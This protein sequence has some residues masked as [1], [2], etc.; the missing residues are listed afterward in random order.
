MPATIIDSAIFQGIFSSDEMRH[1]WSDENHARQWTGSLEQYYRLLKVGYLA[2]K[3]AN[4]RA[5]VL[6]AGMTYWW[7]A[8]YGREQYFQRLLRLGQLATDFPEIEQIDINPLIVSGRREA[9]FVVDARVRL[10][11]SAPAAAGGGRPLGARR[12]G[13]AAGPAGL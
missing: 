6:M 1:V 11:P 7:D 4:P 10:A 5:T 3:S 8:A 9:S 13:G 12:A 2:A